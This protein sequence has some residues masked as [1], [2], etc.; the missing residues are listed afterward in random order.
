MMRTFVVQRRFPALSSALALAMM[1]GAP[2]IVR[3]QDSQPPAPS[4]PA[5]A[6]GPADSVITPPKLVERAE[7]TYPPAALA[8]RVEGA[9]G[10]RLTIS[11]LGEVTKVEV[12][13]SA[14]NGFDEAAM[15]AAV[16]FKFEPARKGT[17]PIASRILYRY[18][19]KL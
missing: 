16:K 6:P 7:A 19:F 14:G 2:T 15:E 1:L 9:V 10:L 11:K 4:A 13:D 8:I 12:I 18:E 3:A 17:N 5:P